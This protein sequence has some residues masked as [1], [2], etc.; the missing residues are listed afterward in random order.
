VAA[1]EQ[2]DAKSRPR[3]TPKPHL[4]GISSEAQKRR[5]PQTICLKCLQKVV[6]IYPRGQELLSPSVGKFLAI[7]GAS[8]I[9]PFGSV[10]T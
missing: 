4:A 6:S 8:P 10:D 3:H 9:S 7:G 1:S 5:R 2:V